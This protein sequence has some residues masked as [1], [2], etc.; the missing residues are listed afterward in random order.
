MANMTLKDWEKVNSSTPLRVVFYG[1]VST[2]HE[3]QI[4]ALENQLQWYQDIAS[5]NSNWT[6]VAPVETYLD[7]GITGTQ[8]KKRPGF[9]QMISDAKL[10]KFDMAVTREVSRFGRNTLEALQYSRELKAAG[11]QVYF[12]ND[13]ISTIKD[14]DAELKLGLMASFAQ[15][16]SRKTSSR[17][18]AGQY[19]SRQKGVLY[20]T[21]NILGYNRVK[22]KGDKSSDSTP[23]FTVDEEQAETVRMIYRLYLSGLGLKKIKNE[24]EKECRKTATGLMSWDVSTISRVLD[25]PMYMG[26]QYQCQTTVEEFLSH[27]RK[28]NSKEDFILIDGD[29][30]PIIDEDTFNKVK[31]L[32]QKKGAANPFKGEKG[33]TFTN[34][35]WSSKLECDC[36]STFKRFQWNPKADSTIPIGYSCRKK[37]N[38]GSLA[39]R[40]KNGMDIAD[41]CDSKSIPEW[42]LE[43]AGKTV[44]SSLITDKRAAVLENYA[45]IERCYCESRKNAASDSADAMK[46][47]SKNEVKL[48]RLVDLYTEGDIEIAEYREKRAS[49]EAAITQAKAQL[50]AE[51]E[52]DAEDEKDDTLIRAFETLAGI[53]NMSDGKVNNLLMKHYVDKVVVR[54]YGFDFMI[55]LKGDATEFAVSQAE[56]RKNEPYAVRAARTNK[57]LEEQ[58]QPA[59]ISVLDFETARKYRKDAGDY[60]RTNQWD[61]KV[62]KVFIRK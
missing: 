51:S 39:F 53:V 19:S 30:A 34:D 5:R 2:E 40:Q 4:H 22:R 8:A 56:V 44:F 52:Y 48:K 26:K 23:T 3:A 16:E 10:G 45:I 33:A 18:K 58:Y 47:I 9:M 20:G 41:A 50:Q 27:E 14:D 24:L 42:H 17:V 55:N 57:M 12:V 43:L 15:E 29:F 35:K 36:G 61:D 59:F 60:L 6:V 32:R 28:K 37:V 21:G 46:V 49:Y 25:N 31:A 11:V 7:K 38:D 1:R 13:N 54:P 62:V